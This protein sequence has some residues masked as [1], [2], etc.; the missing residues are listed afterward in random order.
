MFKRFST[1]S[2]TDKIWWLTLLWYLREK[3]V[4]TVPGWSETTSIW[5]NKKGESTHD[6]YAYLCCKS[7]IK[8]TRLKLNMCWN[9][10]FFCHTIWIRTFFPYNSS[11]AFFVNILSAAFEPRYA[12]LLYQALQHVMRV[13][14]R[15]WKMRPMIQCEKWDPPYNVHTIHQGDCHLS[16]RL[17][18]ICWQRWMAV[19]LPTGRKG[20]EVRRANV[21]ESSVIWVS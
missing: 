10:N 11:A 17:L 3:S 15:S 13:A 4:S 9:T 2:S 14:C 16:T 19:L 21:R 5:N 1:H 18:R 6:E 20:G 12:Y 7:S 8:K